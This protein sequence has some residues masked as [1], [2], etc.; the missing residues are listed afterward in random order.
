MELLVEDGAGGESPPE[1]VL[2]AGFF[3]A[4]DEI[5]EVDLAHAKVESEVVGVVRLV[6]ELASGNN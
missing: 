5:V 6:A 2:E 1:I 3:F 4:V